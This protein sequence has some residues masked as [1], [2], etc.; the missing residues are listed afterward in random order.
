MNL[1]EVFNKLKH[2]FS[3]CDGFIKPVHS[4]PEYQRGECRFCDKVYVLRNNKWEQQW[5]QR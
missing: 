5:W 1:L 2:L 3:G 4:H